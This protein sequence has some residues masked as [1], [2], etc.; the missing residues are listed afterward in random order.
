M[1]N[2][3]D[4]RP[5]YL[6]RRFAEAVTST[7]GVISWSKSSRSDAC[8]RR[9]AGDILPYNFLHRRATMPAFPLTSW[10]T[11]PLLDYCTSCIESVVQCPAIDGAVVREL[12]RRFIV[13]PSLESTDKIVAL[14]SLGAAEQRLQA[15]HPTSSRSN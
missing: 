14:L 10:I 5:P 6:D 15:A 4:I 8:V 3:L 2:S 7:P 9:L 11:G 12:W 1:A 13:H